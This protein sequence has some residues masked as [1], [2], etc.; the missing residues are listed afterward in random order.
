MLN[1]NHEKNSL[2][3]RFLGGDL[4]LGFGGGSVF[5]GAQSRSGDAG[6]GGGGLDFLPQ[7]IVGLARVSV[8]AQGVQP[9][10]H[11]AGHFLLVLL[12]RLNRS[13]K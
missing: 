7:L 13:P 5:G 4:W 12:V 8:P 2:H 1:Q 3:D 6:G 11:V 9:V 10:G